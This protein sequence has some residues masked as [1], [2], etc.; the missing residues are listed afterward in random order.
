MYRLRD[1]EHGETF[2]DHYCVH[3]NIAAHQA[4][5]NVQHSRCLVEEILAGFQRLLAMDAMP[6]DKTKPAA[7]HSGRFKFTRGP[8]GR[9][10]PPPQHEFLPLRRDGRQQCPR[11]PAASSEGGEQHEYHKLAQIR[12]SLDEEWALVVSRWSLDFGR[13]SLVCGGPTPNTPPPHHPRMPYP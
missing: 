1:V 13:Q 8:A 5:V 9:V 6:E 2:G 10:P 7:D 12:D 3:V 4:V 11:Q